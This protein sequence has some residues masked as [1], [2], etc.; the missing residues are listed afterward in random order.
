MDISAYRVSTAYNKQL[1]THNEFK[2][3][4]FHRR[5]C[6]C[7]TTGL[8]VGYCSIAPGT[9]GSILGFLLF[10]PFQTTSLFYALPIITLL[11]GVGVYTTDFASTIFGEKDPPKIVI[12][13][14]VAI[15]LTLFL[16]PPSAV[17]W[18]FG[19]L[20]FRLFDI[21]KPPGVREAE[22]LPGGWGIMADDI[23]A[24]LYTLLIIW[25]AFA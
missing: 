2:M 1:P 25:L 16:L 19:F 18:G 13:E 17:S 9:A 14:I 7:Y 24:A 15:L 10:L 12:D 20:L 5:F 6:Q 4:Q 22:N 11:F 8:G 23:V 3:S 21:A